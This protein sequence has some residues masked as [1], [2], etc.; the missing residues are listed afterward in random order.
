[1]LSIEERFFQKIDKTSSCWLWTAGKT[2]DGY[3]KFRFENKTRRAHMVSY[4]LFKGEIPKGKLI[5][6]THTGNR[7]C[8]NPDHLY[9]GTPEENVKDCIN[10]GTW[11]NGNINKTHCKR[12]HEFTKEN[13][14]RRKNNSRECKVCIK[15]RANAS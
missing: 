8:V 2:W 1:M 11:T 15:E 4:I 5:C 10:H 12:G 14:Y 13:T 9:A 7:H 6:H 3:G